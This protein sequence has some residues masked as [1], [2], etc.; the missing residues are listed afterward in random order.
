MMQEICILKPRALYGLEYMMI[1]PEYPIASVKHPA[2]S[3]AAKKYV[4]ALKPR[5]T[6]ARAA[7]RKKAAKNALKPSEG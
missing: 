3:T 1:L 7:M 2:D 4:F 6:C 5:N